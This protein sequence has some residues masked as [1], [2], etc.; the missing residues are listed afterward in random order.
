M[1]VTISDSFTLRVIV[2]G[3][4]DHTF[5][6]EHEKMQSCNYLAFLMLSPITQMPDT[7]TTES[8]LTP[9][10]LTGAGVWALQDPGALERS[11]SSSAVEFY[12][13]S[14]CPLVWPPE[15]HS[16]GFPGFCL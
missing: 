5:V 8:L 13:C 2:L 6:N 3:E 14:P 16:L 11:F 1:R 7:S 12:L 4:K 9:C 15:S 10:E